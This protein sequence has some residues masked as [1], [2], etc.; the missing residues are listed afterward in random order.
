MEKLCIRSHIKTRLL[1]GLTAKQ[2]HE[3]LTTAY[4]QDVVSY[5]TVA[6]WVHRFSSGPELLEDD[7]QG[8]RSIAIVTQENTGIV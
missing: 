8:G 1:L 2:I 5:S 4:G 7:P 3:A 6:L